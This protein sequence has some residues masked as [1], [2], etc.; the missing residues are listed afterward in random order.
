MQEIAE[1]W[2]EEKRKKSA[3]KEKARRQKGYRVIDI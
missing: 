3:E 1:E 2:L